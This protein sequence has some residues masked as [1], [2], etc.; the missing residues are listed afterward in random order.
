MTEDMI[1][2]IA[3]AISY[4]DLPQKHFSEMGVIKTGIGKARRFPFCCDIPF[5]VQTIPFG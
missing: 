5:W 1:P 2:R 3:E 4:I